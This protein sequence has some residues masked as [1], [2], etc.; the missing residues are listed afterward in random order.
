M[1]AAWRSRAG[2]SRLVVA[3]LVEAV[4]LLH[5]QRHLCWAPRTRARPRAALCTGTAPGGQPVMRR[6]RGR[7]AAATALLH[8][9]AYVRYA[10]LHGA[11]TGATRRLHGRCAAVAPHQ[12]RSTVQPGTQEG[13]RPPQLCPSDAPSAEY[14]HLKGAVAHG[15]YT[16]A[17][18]RLHG[19]YTLI[20]AFRCTAPAPAPAVGLLRA[21]DH[22][23]VTASRLHRAVAAS[24]TKPRSVGDQVPGWLALTIDAG[25]RSP[26]P[27]HHSPGAHGR[28][29]LRC[30]RGGRADVRLRGAVGHN[31]MSSRRLTSAT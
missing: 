26:I 29:G 5:H 15:G 11:C 8:C 27:P 18:R 30:H 24:S 23:A 19:A 25:Q 22:T 12:S 4:L 13:P 31:A 6:L 1:A 3:P 14:A 17:I 16:A 10:R 21:C 28:Q 7:R 20:A 9:G 2:G